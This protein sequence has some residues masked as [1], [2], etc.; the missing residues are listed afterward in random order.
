LLVTLNALVVS[1]THYKILL[2]DK[3]A[4]FL[5]EVEFGGEWNIRCVVS[6]EELVINRRQVF[7][8]DLVINN[9]VIPD[10]I[11]VQ[12]NT[13]I[14][15]QASL[16]VQTQQSQEVSFRRSNR[17]KEVQFWIIMVYFFKNMNITLGWL[18]NI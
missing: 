11:L 14:P 16:M 1:Q 10:I 2:W 9:N 13:K 4:R 18:R 8:T 7:V 3:N 6:D 17:E 12:D 15:P 5:E